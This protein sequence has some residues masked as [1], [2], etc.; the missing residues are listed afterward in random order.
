MSLIDN[1]IQPFWINGLNEITGRQSSGFCNW[2]VDGNY[3]I[4]T[5]IKPASFTLDISSVSKSSLLKAFA[6]DCNRMAAASFESMQLIGK[7]E[8]LPKSTAWLVIQSYYSAFFAAHSILRMIG[9]SC[10]QLENTPIRKIQDIADIFS[11]KPSGVTIKSGYYKCRYDYNSD[12]LYCEHLNASGGSHE[13]FWKT[14]HNELKDI[15]NKILSTPSIPIADA[16]RVSGQ[17][18]VMCLNLCHHGESRGNWLSHIRNKVNYQHEFNCWFPYQDIKKTSV[19]ELYETSQTWLIDPMQISLT[20]RGEIL[21]FHRT[22][23]FIVSLCRT[24]VEYMSDRCPE[25]RKKYLH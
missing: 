24:L 13:N 7:N 19:S 1:A 5:D 15:S 12:K 3:Q 20:A 16:Q 6:F 22:C 25:G 14:F 8:L 2:I 18:D 17:I 21:L 10:S 11:C 23:N 4:Y 9:I